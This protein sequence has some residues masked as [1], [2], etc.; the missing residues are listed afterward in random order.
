MNS[1]TRLLSLALA[2]VLW[3]P[4]AAQA[5]EARLA[6]FCVFGDSLSD[7][8]NVFVVT[9]ELSRRPFGLVPSAPYPRGGINFSNGRLWIDHLARE[10]RRRRDVRP[11]L[12]RP[13]RFCNYAFGGARARQIDPA[14]FDL[15]V[16][17]AT[18]LND[19]GATPADG[20]LFVVFLG[21]NDIRD[22]LVALATDPTGAASA[23]IIEQTVVNIGNH[24]LALYNLAGG[25]RFLVFNA[26]NVGFLPAVR[27][28][29]PAAQAAAD[30]LSE[31]FAAGLAATLDMLEL[32]PGIEVARVDL[33]GLSNA[34]AANPPAGITNTTDPCI[35]PGVIQGA[36]CDH[37]DQ[38]AFWDGIHPTRVVHRLI[39]ETA[40]RALAP[41][42]PL[43]ARQ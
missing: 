43:A 7:T 20:T 42:V 2:A 1:T 37:P 24:I 16:Q 29:G 19:F 3:L 11:A 40:D 41:M 18:Y 8:G 15:P 22:A 33:L 28:A 31:A 38:F 34:I 36:I 26:P 27:L 23:A 4:F 30:Q 25:R 6:Q 21:G 39:F 14:R 10:L 13:G 5:D 12:R 32:L 9:R 17:L 35:T